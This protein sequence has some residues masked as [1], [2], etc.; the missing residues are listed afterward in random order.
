MENFREQSK[1][2][3][4]RY[5]AAL[6]VNVNNE[7]VSFEEFVKPHLISSK[8][9]PDA[10]QSAIISISRWPNHGL[11]ITLSYLRS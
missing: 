10:P 9:I 8:K 2:E 5:L 11:C 7:Q 3:T 6:A 4:D 1:R